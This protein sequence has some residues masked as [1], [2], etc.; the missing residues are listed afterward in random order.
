MSTYLIPL[1]NHD[2]SPA[3]ELKPF[4][5]IKALTKHVLPAVEGVV[6]SRGNVVCYYKDDIRQCSL[7]L[8][9]S[10][11]LHHRGDSIVLNSESAPSILGVSS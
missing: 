5:Y 3:L 11:A 6:I 1:E 7:L 8:Q 9:D 2:K 10:V 4:Q